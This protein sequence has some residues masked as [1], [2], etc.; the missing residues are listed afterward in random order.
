METSLK[1]LAGQFTN[2]EM[3]EMKYEVNVRGKD[4]FQVAKANL[5]RKKLLQ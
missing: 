5:K 3:R 2:D 1:K 4:A